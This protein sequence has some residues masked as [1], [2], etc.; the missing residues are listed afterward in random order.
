MS[1]RGAAVATAPYVAARRVAS[2]LGPFGGAASSVRAASMAAWHAT[3][4][5]AAH[6]VATATEPR[7]LP[8][9]VSVTSWVRGVR[10]DSCVVNT[11]C[12]V[13]PLQVGLDRNEARVPRSSGGR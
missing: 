5:P 12:V 11:V 13:A 10:D 2:T 4:G 8:P 1:A 3:L 6:A 7:S 9:T